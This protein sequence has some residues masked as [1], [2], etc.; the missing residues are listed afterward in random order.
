MKPVAKY[1]PF[2]RTLLC[3]NVLFVA[4]NVEIAVPH[5][6]PNTPIPYSYGP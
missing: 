3:A 6:A 4:F 5:G 1:P 2:T